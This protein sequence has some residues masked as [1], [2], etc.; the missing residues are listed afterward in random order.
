MGAEQSNL[1][2]MPNGFDYMAVTFRITDRIRLIYP[3][4][5]D[6]N[7]T[8]KV[9]LQHWPKGRRSNYISFESWHV[10]DR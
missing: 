7:S 3:T 2:P 10:V 9:L 4:Q 1:V 5:E 6:I 8:R